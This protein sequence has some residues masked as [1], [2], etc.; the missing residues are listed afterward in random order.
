MINEEWSLE[1]PGNIPDYSF[2]PEEVVQT[3]IPNFLTQRPPVGNLTVE[4]SSE[5]DVV[6][7]AQKDLS[8]EDL[9]FIE[10]ADKAPHE[11]F[12]NW[13]VLRGEK[14]KMKEI[15]NWWENHEE[16]GISGLI[17]LKKQIKRI[18]PYMAFDGITKP[19]S[20]EARDFS[21]PSG[22]SYGAHY[23]AANLSKRYPHLATGLHTLA[24]KI[25]NTRIQAGVHYPS[26]IEAG[27]LLA[28][29]MVECQ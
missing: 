4:D 1:S 2:L 7:K 11:I 14:P 29:K 3:L 21:F 16:N 12:Y 9:R 20:I 13:L 24:D 22:H 19:A 17:A 15:R 6:R 18:R 10:Q 26:D 27:K 5:A 8:D 25:A 28:L 23:I